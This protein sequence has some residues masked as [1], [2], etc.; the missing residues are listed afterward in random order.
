[1]NDAYAEL[2]EVVRYANRLNLERES[3]VGPS[4]SRGRPGLVSKLNKDLSKAL[5]IR[6]GEA[7]A[8]FHTALS[9]LTETKVDIPGCTI[10]HHLY[11]EVGAVKPQFCGH[12]LCEPC[13]QKLARPQCPQCRKELG[14]AERVF[15]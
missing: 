9:S 5:K 7:L 6:Q 14:V 2:L 15:V 12:I 4:G 13:Y 11:E 10:C 3:G 8:A 1:L